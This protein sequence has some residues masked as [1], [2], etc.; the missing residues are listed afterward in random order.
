MPYSIQVHY[1]YPKKLASLMC[2]QARKGCLMKRF[3]DNLSSLKKNINEDQ[4]RITV[5]VATIS[6]ANRAT[7]D[8]IR[9]LD[10]SN[11]PDY[12]TTQDFFS[13]ARLCSA[14]G[15]K[16]SF[17]LM[18]WSN[19]VFGTNLVDYVPYDENYGR[20]DFRLNGRF[21]DRGGILKK[22]VDNL[23]TELESGHLNHLPFVQDWKAAASA[24][25]AM[26]LSEAVFN[27]RFCNNYM[28]FVFENVQVKKKEW[29]K[30]E[31]STFERTT[32]IIH[33]SFEL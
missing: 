2:F 11:L 14:E 22:L 3:I 28:G 9:K 4:I 1:K 18:N 12:L 29:R 16:H 27:A 21:M 5:S 6:P 13:A 17:H 24:M 7:V 33:A 19:R 32:S 26:D 25:G 31:L 10:W 23:A 20:R 15:T 8:E 30:A